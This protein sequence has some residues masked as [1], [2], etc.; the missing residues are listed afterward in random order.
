MTENKPAS[1]KKSN[2]F[3]LIS[4]LL[5]IAS[6][7][8][9]WTSWASGTVGIADALP[10]VWNT[11][12]ETLADQGLSIFSFAFFLYAILES[13]VFESLFASRNEWLKKRKYFAIALITIGVA[14]LSASLSWFDEYIHFYPL[15]IPLF[16]A[17][18]FDFFSAF[19]CLY[20]GS[21]AGLIGLASPERMGKYI[22]NQCGV[23]TSIKF[24][25]LFGIDFRLLFF[26]IFTAIIVLFNIWY[27]NKI[28]QK[29][30]ADKDELI[31]EK[32][33]YPFDKTRKIVLFVAGFFLIISILGQ[34]A[35]FAKM[36]ERSKITDKTP[37]E[38]TGKY[39][40][41][42]HEDLGEIGNGEVKVAKVVTDAKKSYWGRFGNWNTRSLDCWFIFGGII[43]CLITKLNV[44]KTFV[45]A[46]QNG[47]PLLFI[48][49]LSAA[50]AE[51]IKGSG[52][53]DGLAGK[54]LPETSS[55]NAGFLML[56]SIFVLSAIVGFFICSTAITAS[57][58]SVSRPALLAISSQTFI[59]AGIF[60]W[61]GGILGMAFS[62]TNG[63][64]V[65][66]LERSETSYKEF[67]KKTWKL[68]LIVTL[69]TFGLV[70]FW[71][72]FIIK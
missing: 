18:G 64:L 47:L 8:L 10:C 26:A 9:T 55:P 31:K 5:I 60:S 70:F 24:D 32:N 6:I 57:L 66:S 72:K 45:V 35:P 19:L 33:S 25:G 67:I 27:C 43:I 50:P 53:S 23:G 39:E 7:F 15:I 11:A 68:W 65:A 22:R 4:F 58:V 34:F 71:A 48:Y 49:V 54:I 40:E 36:I 44:A 41:K 21:I 30:E 63:I 59:Y 42:E 12:K 14:I 28:E 46:A 13:K 2:Y 56:F 37:E 38:F 16:L 1:Q 52:F 61:V 62:P 20:G 69:V 51:I 3:Y 17:M 29:K